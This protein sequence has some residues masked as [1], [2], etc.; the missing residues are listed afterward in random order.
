MPLRLVK[1]S[2]SETALTLWL[3]RL[4]EM[5]WENE[6]APE[7][8]EAARAIYRRGE[9]REINAA[10]DEVAARGQWENGGGRAIVEWRDGHLRWRATTESAALGA[11]LAAATLYELEE[12]VGDEMAGRTGIPNNA[13]AA[14]A[15]SRPKNEHSAPAQTDDT[16]E[17]ALLLLAFSVE[18]DGGVRCEPRWTA[19]DGVV[20]PAYGTEAPS[21][22]TINLRQSEALLRLA[23]RARHWGFSFDGKTAWYLAPSARVMRFIREE[24]PKWKQRWRVEGEESLADFAREAPPLLLRADAEEMPEN[25]DILEDTDD[26][27]PAV[28]GGG[29]SGSLAK[30][31]FDGGCFR[32][33]WRLCLG[34]NLLP[35]KLTRRVLN[36]PG[37]AVFMPK[38]GLVR[39]NDKQ[40]AAIEQWGAHP[41]E[42]PRHNLPALLADD[43]LRTEVS[44]P[45]SAWRAALSSEPEL[46]PNLPAFLRPYQARGVAWLAHLL[47]LGAHPLLADEMGLG[48]TVQTLALIHGGGAALSEPVLIVCPASVIPVWTAETARFFPETPVRVLR[49]GH[50]WTACPDPVLWLASYAN[51]RLSR[52]ALTDIEFAYAV[53]DEAQF[54]KNPDSKTA[55]ACMGIRARRRLALTGTPLENHPRDLWTIFRFLM[56]SLLGELRVFEA[57]LE[58]DPAAV[59]RIA[60]QVAPFVL[61]RVKQA[62]APELPPK[63]V[64]PLPCQM[65]ETQR[66]L[67][68]AI[69]TEGLAA[70]DDTSDD[71]PDTRAPLRMPSFLALLTRLRQVACDPALLPNH[72]NS[73]L[74]ASGK[75]TVLAE[76]LAEVI[77]SGKKVVVFSQFV[78]LIDRVALLIERHFSSIPVF[79]LTGAT[80]DRGTPVAMFQQ[81][82]G[83][84]V[85]L[86]SLRA[87]GTGVTLNSA[88]YVFLLDPWW[89]PAVEEQAIDRAHRIGQQNPVFVYRMTTEGTVEARVEALK[90]AKTQLFSRLVGD[91]PDRSDWRA[92]LPAL[93]ALI[94]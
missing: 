11:A 43:R 83:S 77:E 19:S 13:P 4:A 28:T 7:V 49:R 54:I 17:A 89:N 46:P 85:M 1:R 55:R 90:E 68:R 91:M 52:A 84:A 60:S 26:Y 31:R 35:D 62:V 25:G 44:A 30:K 93:R 37:S 45:L 69:A 88:E 33:R 14:S 64:M 20:V 42:L 27:T 18:D 47:A 72:R 5:C 29:G 58:R 74:S 3:E 63:V 34:D 22:N 16:D 24:L 66:E 51:L 23:T 71:A 39:L 9:I 59:T 40:R 57:L 53:L 86:A 6:F 8:L 67:Y 32:I 50:D 92:A 21:P 81:C 73:P 12:L 76:R 82:Q 36:S 70:L 41:A 10:N 75:L 78:R 56:P 79:R 65:S 38:L 48:K 94:E 61:R 80:A 15:R 87:A 2:H